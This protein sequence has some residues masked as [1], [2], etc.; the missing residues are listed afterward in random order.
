MPWSSSTAGSRPGQVQYTSSTP[1]R[2]TVD[3]WGMP[4]YS[5]IRDRG[6]AR[7]H[8]PARAPSRLRVARAPRS[9]QGIGP[10]LRLELR[11]PAPAA[12]GVLA[13]VRRRAADAPDHGKRR[14]ALRDLP[15][16]RASA[17]DVLRDIAAARL[18]GDP[19]ERRARE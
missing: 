10:R 4:E 8:R 1:S 12:P 14:A 7:A 17:M 18:R 15:L 3:R 6:P 19:R 13:L 2:V 9:L 16:R 11:E 5:S